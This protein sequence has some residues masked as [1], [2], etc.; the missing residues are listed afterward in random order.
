MEM[1]KIGQSLTFQLNG[2]K[3]LSSAMHM[4]QYF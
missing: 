2:Q 4:I 1:S 3:I